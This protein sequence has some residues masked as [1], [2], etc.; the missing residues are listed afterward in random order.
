MAK[1]K[2]KSAKKKITDESFE[3]TIDELVEVMEDLNATG[4]GLQKKVVQGPNGP[5]YLS[6]LELTDRV[7]YVEHFRKGDVIEAHKATEADWTGEN[8]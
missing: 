3:V 7:I 2:K 6:R 8:N 1:K 5:R 4:G